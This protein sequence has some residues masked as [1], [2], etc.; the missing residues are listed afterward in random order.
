MPTIALTGC[1]AD[2]IHKVLL[3]YFSCQLIRIKIKALP[4]VS[5]G[6]IPDTTVIR[7]A[8]EKA[9]T[10]RLQTGPRLSGLPAMSQAGNTS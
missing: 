3:L 9:T 1:S 4:V 2:A 8:A 5:P 10:V 7:T 6:G